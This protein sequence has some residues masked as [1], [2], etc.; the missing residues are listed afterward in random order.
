MTFQETSLC[1][2]F[3]RAPSEH[4]PSDSIL[5]TCSPQQSW[6]QNWRRTHEL[7]TE[8]GSV[9]LFSSQ[10]F[11]LHDLRIEVK[12]LTFSWPR[13]QCIEGEESEKQRY[14]SLLLGDSTTFVKSTGDGYSCFSLL[15]FHQNRV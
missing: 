2:R 12:S 14:I 4:P 7:I 15:Y 8:H 1:Q 10:I 6:P 3:C 13:E 5:H 11:T 9:F